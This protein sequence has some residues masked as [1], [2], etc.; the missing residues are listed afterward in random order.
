MNGK[1]LLREKKKKKIGDDENGRK[2]MKRFGEEEGD[3]RM[4][5]V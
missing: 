3:L 4:G 5:E 1:I 2:E